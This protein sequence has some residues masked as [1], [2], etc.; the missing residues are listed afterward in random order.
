MEIEFKFQV[1]AEE[2][3][4]VENALRVGEVLQIDLEARYFDTADGRLAAAGIALRL[5]S[6]NGQWLQ[7]VK[8]RGEGV[9]DRFEHNVEL[10]AAP[11]PNAVPD[12]RLHK[13][14]KVGRLLKAALGDAALCQTFATEISRVVRY[15]YEGGSKAEIAL[16]LG[17]VRTV[18]A[19]GAPLRSSPVCELEIELVLGDAA[20]LASVARRWIDRH[21]LFVSTLSKSG[22]GARLLEESPLIAAVKAEPP[23]FAEAHGEAPDGAEIQRRVVAACLAQVL[24]NAS[25]VAAGNDSR[26]IVHQLRVGLRRLRTALRELDG[27]AAG[28]FQPGWEAPL[29]R[30]FAALGEQ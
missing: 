3:T 20:D 23:R 30:V 6:E 25:E 16:D 4:P 18:D 8:A 13:G 7:T 5:R 10:A 14:T 17:E 2:V 24:P 9:L 1:P 12:I 22:R 11:Q 21:G 28:N 15:E 27:L 26:D 19:A 29:S